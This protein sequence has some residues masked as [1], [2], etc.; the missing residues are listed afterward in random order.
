MPDPFM[1]DPKS[2]PEWAKGLLDCCWKEVKQNKTTKR[3]S[4]CRL[5]TR[6]RGDCV[7]KDGWLRNNQYPK[8]TTCQNRHSS[9][10]G[11]GPTSTDLVAI[12]SRRISNFRGTVL[13][14]SLTSSSRSGRKTSVLVP[15]QSALITSHRVD[16]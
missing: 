2:H 3:W 7:D 5:N 15:F 4:H 12:S 8:G 11:S 14:R 9:Y 6:H 13:M 1:K 16:P 10:V